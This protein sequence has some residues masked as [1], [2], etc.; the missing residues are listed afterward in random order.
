VRIGG[1]KLRMRRGHGIVLPPGIA[2]QYAA[3][4]RDPWTIVWFHFTGARAA[5][6]AQALTVSRE[7][8]RFW[9]EN[10]DAIIEAFEECYH[11]VLGGYT[12]ADLVGL[13]TSFTR[14]TGLCRT[15]QRSPNTRRRHAQNRIA[16][17]VRYLRENLHRKLTLAQIAREAGMSVP[18]FCARFKR[19]FNCG[20]IKFFERM[21]MHR[22]CEL[23]DYTE[24][25]VSEIAAA[26]GFDDPFYFSKR[27]RRH[28]GAS[29]TGHRTQA[30]H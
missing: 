30:R 27:F 24:H 4:S 9:V 3:D 7:Q 10:T 25:R 17:S 26:L 1:S 29:P 22:A 8:P 18:Y 13:S 12:D 23:L 28:A 5:D 2:H 14:F 6:C 11:H 20:P 15:L 16:G 21:K 19:Q